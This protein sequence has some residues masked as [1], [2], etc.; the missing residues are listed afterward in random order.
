MKKTITKITSI[1]LILAFALTLSA[2]K[3]PITDDEAKDIAKDLLEKEIVLTQFVYGN[4][5]KLAKQSEYDQHKNDTTYYYAK[6]SENSSFTTKDQLIAAINEIYTERVADEVM[7]FA[8]DGNSGSEGA[9]II[10]RFY[11]PKDEDR[12]KIDVTSYG[13]YDLSAVILLDTL[14]VKRSTGSMIDAVVSYKAG[15]SDITREMTVSLRKVD[16]EWKLD[17]R[18]WAVGVE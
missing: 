13:V 12:L 8:I 1:L 3:G 17:I 16:G 5:I 4:D 15:E 6:V 2:C 14:V 11:Q 18:T 10:P 7:E 9:T